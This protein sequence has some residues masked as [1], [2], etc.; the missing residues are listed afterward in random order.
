MHEYCVVHYFVFL[1]DGVFGYLYSLLHM[2]IT[3]LPSNIIQ[4]SLKHVSHVDTHYLP[5]TLCLVTPLLRFFSAGLCPV[6][7]NNVFEVFPQC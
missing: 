5:I 3:T 1:N 7:V 2:H 4:A 6:Q